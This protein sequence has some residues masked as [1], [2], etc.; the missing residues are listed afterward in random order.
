MK[1]GILTF[2]DALN[3]GAVLQA[4]ALQS[5]LSEIRNNKVEIINYRPENRPKFQPSVFKASNFIKQIVG[6]C[7]IAYYR[8]SF[9]LRD[10]RFL[11]F[12]TKYHNLSNRVYTSLDDFNKYCHD[13][14]VLIAGSD[15]VFNPKKDSQVYYLGFN[16]NGCKRIAYAPSIGLV[17]LSPEQKA[18]IRPW[19]NN[20]DALS[21]RESEG[22]KLL[23]SISHSDVPVVCD[24][25]CL[26]SKQQWHTIAE[27]PNYDNYIFV[28]D[29]NGGKPL[30]D[31]AVKLKR[32]TGL[33]I[34]YSSLKAIHPY[35]NASRI[36]HDLGPAE[37]LGHIINASYVVTDSFHGTML[38]LVLGIPVLCKI[39]V[40]STSS[41]I[42]TI[43]SRLGIND[44]LVE[45][46][47]KF[48]IKN[49]KFSDYQKILSEF[50]KDS[51]DYLNSALDGS[52]S[53]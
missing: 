48:N 5:Y 37:W 15:Q 13:Y 42:T 18:M 11:Q 40:A 30:F 44:Q 16:A 20:F 46:I 33:P 22:A 45:N 14:S 2:H 53:I 47:E 41:R 38:S 24:P 49:V 7:I 51:K 50:I 36:R 8:R 19:V 6:N 25:V 1:V 12:S 34:V 39:A 4:Y 3:Y 52:S 32:Q 31:L 21:C 9:K 17:E 35:V 10:K 23:S 27:R 29:L 43:M 28:F 26:I